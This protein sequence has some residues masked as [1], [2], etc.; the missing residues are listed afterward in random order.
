MPISPKLKWKR[1]YNELKF[2][3]DEEEFIQSIC[4]EA[5]VEFEAYYTVFCATHKIDGAK[6]R[7]QLY[8]KH[9]QRQQSPAD[10]ASGTLPFSGSTPPST[11]L[12]LYEGSEE[13]EEPTE[14]LDDFIEDE[15][16]HGLFKKLFKKIALRLHPDKVE[17]F[18]APGADK[19]Q[20]VKDFNR[21]KKALEEKKYYILIEI[22]ERYNITIPRSYPIQNKWFKATIR[23]SQRLIKTQKHSYNYL[24]AECETDEHRDRLM[25]GFLKQMFG[26][27]I[28]QKDS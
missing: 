14:P 25:R 26:P 10:D 21:A 12:Q 13:E 1:L 7:Q 4:E 19:H 18:F 17:N 20:M 23:K 16:L 6:L 22:A 15:E 9:R 5:S 2:L 27:Q 3:K 24:F 28:F 11:E 8:E